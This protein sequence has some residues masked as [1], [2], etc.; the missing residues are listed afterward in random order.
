MAVHFFLLRSN[1]PER[2]F[3]GVQLTL[4]KYTQIHAHT[5]THTHTQQSRTIGKLNHHVGIICTMEISN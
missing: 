3:W 5:H 2:E 1:I 4:Y